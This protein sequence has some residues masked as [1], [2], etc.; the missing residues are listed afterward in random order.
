MQQYRQTWRV[1]HLAKI[2]QRKT[3]A[4]CFHLHVKYV[5]DENI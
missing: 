5:F 2:S 1:F 4:T 3:N